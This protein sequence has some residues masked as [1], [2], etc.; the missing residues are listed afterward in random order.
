[1]AY[2]VASSGKLRTGRAY[3]EP[4][5]NL[6]RGFGS[7]Q[8]QFFTS[9]S[10]FATPANVYQDA[11]LTT[12]FAPTGVVT[13]DNNGLFPKI[14]LDTSVNYGVQLV[15]ANLTVL[16][17]YS[18][19]QGSLANTGTA[20]TFNAATGLSTNAQGEY[21]VVPVAGG[22]GVGITINA[23][24]PAGI[25]LKVSAVAPGAVTITINSS[26]TTGVQ[27]ATFAANN[28]PGN[29]AQLVV[30]GTAAPS[31][32]WT[33][34][35]L[36]AAWTGL[37]GSFFSIILSTGQVIPNCT[38]TNGSTSYST[39]STSITPTPN[40]T[41]TVQVQIT[42]T[43]WL[44]INID[45]STMYIPLWRGDQF[46]PI[47]TPPQVLGQTITL[48]GG[49]FSWNSDG[50]T[51]VPG[52]SATPSNWYLPTTGG[53]G[54]SFWISITKTSGRSGVSFSAAQGAFTN[55]AGGLSVG[56]SG[57]S[58][59][60]LGGT[61]Q[62]SANA[63][64]TQIVASGTITF[65][66]P[67]GSTG[68]N[69]GVAWSGTAPFVLAANGTATL[70]AVGT[71]NWYLPTTANVGASF[72]IN[73]TRTGGTSGCNFTNAQGAWTNITNSGLTIDI[74]GVSVGAF[75][76]SGSYI[77]ASN[78]SGTLQC[79][80]GTITL[81]KTI[82]SLI[83]IYTTTGSHTE[84]IPVNSTTVTIEVW[85]AG[86]GGSSGTGSGCGAQPGSSG[87]AGGYSRT[88]KTVASLGGSGK[89]M[90]AV[91]GTGGT[92]G[93]PGTAGGTST[94]SNGTSSGLTTMTAHGG[95]GAV[96][97]FGDGAGG[98]ASGGTA[99]N[100]TGGTGDTTGTTGSVSGDG[101][102]Y[103]GGGGSGGL[104]GVGHN[105]N[106]GATVFFYQ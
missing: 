17:Q 81:N 46:V 25:P 53:I 56:V 14:Y 28:K 2:V 7:A 44:P 47:Q 92:G 41:L 11:A 35:T 52:G 62:V 83:H 22:S 10:A 15:A 8:W 12:P 70:N 48:T 36:T 21:A 24:A 49:P 64:G 54:S 87:G 37:T 3:Y 93:A 27:T 38:F 42:P 18:Q 74:T 39:P 102:P 31:G 88:V 68:P 13:A 26:A 33:G 6:G 50:S 104:H 30:T 106:N 90:T 72:W 89:T 40:T 99:A 94:V 77:I 69:D 16:R 23:Q 57:A 71:T 82:S 61:Y 58:N 60:F 4:R 105:G 66:S 103:G 29:T 78:S 34:G 51:T 20:A 76:V 80:A 95:A 43:G 45:G 98:T 9:A 5:V 91:N 65:N 84:T 67:S 32:T 79:S 1:M 19:Y 85:G 75:T 59:T 73:I 55:I 86:G 96:G 101:S 63:G 100:I 97:S